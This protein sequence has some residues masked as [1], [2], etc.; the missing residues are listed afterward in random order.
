MD[1]KY[2]PIIQDGLILL[3]ISTLFVTGVNFIA[4]SL[5]KSSESNPVVVAVIQNNLKGM[6]EAFEPK[7]V[8]LPDDQ[9]RTP[10]MWVAYQN[11]RD[12]KAI[13]ETDAKRAPMVDF[14]V[15]KEGNINARDEHGWTPLMW[16]SWSGLTQT[17]SRLVALGADASLSDHKGN[18]ALMMAA[19][20]GNTE[21]VQILVNKGAN[22]KVAA[23]DGMLARDF[24]QK[25][26]TEYPM[27]ANEYQKI[28][29]IL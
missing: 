8:N 3:T 15:Q 21:I 22:T 20:R 7:L 18:T 26:I 9:L 17:A 24:A 10:L 28:L 6:E 1:K 23:A 25:G 5:K 14:L 11:S 29:S 2:K 16:A 19:L 4:K 12:A 13:V 27:K